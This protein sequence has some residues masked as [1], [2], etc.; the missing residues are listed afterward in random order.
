[1]AKPIPGREGAG[2]RVKGSLTG[3]QGIGGSAAW[4]RGKGGVPI[5]PVPQ[6]RQERWESANKVNAL[7]V[8]AR[9]HVLKNVESKIGH[10]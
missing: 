1:M 4:V 3:K 8:F 2:G 6:R 7:F 5:H 9:L 10:R